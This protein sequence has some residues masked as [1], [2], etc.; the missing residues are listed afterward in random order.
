MPVEM[1][2]F[3]DHFEVI[4]IDKDGNFIMKAYYY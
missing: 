2:F 3:D 1:R 4:E